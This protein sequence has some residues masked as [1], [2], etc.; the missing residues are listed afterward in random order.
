MRVVANTVLPLS[1]RAGTIA[2]HA[3]GGKAE[4]IFLRGFD[5]DHGTD[6]NI[7]VDGIPVNMTSHGHGQGYADLHFVIPETIEA[8]MV[9][10]GPYYAQYGNFATAG[11]VQFTTRDR[12]TNNS[13]QIEG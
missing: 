8:I 13:V 2:Q 12:L 11:S 3:G 6:V 5:A 1:N 9:D 7:G 4:Q 10:K